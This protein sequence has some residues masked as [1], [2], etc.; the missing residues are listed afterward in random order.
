MED[1]DDR[2]FGGHYDSH[3]Q[4]VLRHGHMQAL[5]EAQI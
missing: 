2:R 4:P 5:S 1:S 3:P